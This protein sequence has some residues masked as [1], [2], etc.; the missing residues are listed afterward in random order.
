MVGS[1]IVAD[2]STVML[3]KAT[4]LKGRAFMVGPFSI[5]DHSIVVF[6]EATDS[7]AEPSWS[8]RLLYPIT[9]PSCL[10][11]QLTQGWSHH[12]WIVYPS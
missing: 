12:G 1:F 3:K 11:K 4:E 8:D 9:L 6:K 10:K 2:H 5:A 7:R